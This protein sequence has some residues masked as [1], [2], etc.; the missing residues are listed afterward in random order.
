MF[1]NCILVTGGFDPI[2][3][4]HINY[5]RSSKVICDYLVVGINSDEWLKRKKKSLFYKWEERAAIINEFEIVNKVIKFN[6]Y[7]NTAT[8]AIYRCLQFSDN[9]IFA[10]GGD[11]T[12]INIP[13][14][15]FFKDN[16]R[17]SF[18]FGVGGGVKVNSSSSMLQ[19]YVDM[20]LHANNKSN[21]INPDNS[22]FMKPWGKFRTLSTG[23]GYKIKD[24][25]VR[26]KHKLSLQFHLQRSEHW[27]IVQGHALVQLDHH[28][29]DYKVGEHIFIKIGQKHRIT[30]IGEGDLVLVEV[31]LGKYIEEDDIVRLEDDYDR[32]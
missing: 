17:V 14:I 24:I 29:E 27:V 13:E 22:F 1:K 30:N 21:D 19:D 16:S 3:Q 7:D 4:G 8:D 28:I 32:K 5:L 26:P 18:E 9:V 31:A 12:S 23:H 25:H 15:N 2:H 11:R 20:I 10:N 6:D